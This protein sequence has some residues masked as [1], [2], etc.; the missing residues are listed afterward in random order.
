LIVAQLAMALVLL[1]ASGLM[2]RTFGALHTV[3]P[4]FTEPSRQLV[5][6][7][8]VPD[9]L[10]PDDARVALL[11]RGIV[12]RVGAI[13]GV[14]STGFATTIPMEGSLPDWDVIIPEGAH[15]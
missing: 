7:M 10:V 6:Q 8:S 13:P 1:V 3:Q 11:E 15:L 12:E 14:E 4:G 2:L 9:V 5:L